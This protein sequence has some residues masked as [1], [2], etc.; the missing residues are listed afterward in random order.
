MPE[1]ML[2]FVE[3]NQQTPNKR[4]VDSRIDDFNEIYD[5]FIN[6]KA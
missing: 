4:G 3:L 5:Q 1:K 2:K 6:Q